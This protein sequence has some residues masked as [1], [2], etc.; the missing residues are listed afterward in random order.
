MDN[1]N[2][3]IIG[4]IIALIG[5]IIMVISGYI[6]S[7]EKTLIL[8]SVHQTFHMIA[9]FVLGSFSGGIVNALSIPRNILAA[10]D[11]LKPIIKV[12]VIVPTV[13]LSVIFNKIGLIGYLPIISTV[14]YTVFMDKLNPKNF[15]ILTLIT[16][17][18]WCIHDLYVK[19][20]ATFVFD[21][22]GMCTTTIAIIRIQ[23]DIKKNNAEN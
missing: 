4:N 13:A 20:Y 21:I 16:Y 15:K 17:L 11:K 1:T 22:L 12:I 2:R 9:N 6:K 7:K 23:S 10:K 18:P 14:L 5:C 19:D 8:I 3:I